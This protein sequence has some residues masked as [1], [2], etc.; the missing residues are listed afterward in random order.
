MSQS[1]LTDSVFDRAFIARSTFGKA[2][3]CDAIRRA[4][5]L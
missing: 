3:L 1:A 5:G 4:R 2:S